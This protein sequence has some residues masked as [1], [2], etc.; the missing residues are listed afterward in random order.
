MSFSGLYCKQRNI[1]L[2]HLSGRWMDFVSLVF[3]Q[4]KNGKDNNANACYYNSDVRGSLGY[5]G[6]STPISVF[7]QSTNDNWIPTMDSC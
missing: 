3:C 2:G 4:Y 5:H 7:T 1:S 6:I